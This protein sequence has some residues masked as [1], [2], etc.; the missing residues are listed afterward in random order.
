MKKKL[1]NVGGSKA[2]ILPSEI[3]GEL[4]EVEYNIDTMNKKIIISWEWGIKNEN[5]INKTFRNV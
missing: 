1:L 5:W 3:V 4:E 2:I